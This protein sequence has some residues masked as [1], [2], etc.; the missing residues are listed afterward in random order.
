MK[1]GAVRITRHAIERWRQRVDP[2]ASEEAAEQAIRQALSRAEELCDAE[3]GAKAYLAGTLVL[4]VADNGSL[5]TVCRPEYGFGPAIDE[6]I[7]QKLIEQLHDVRRRKAE[8]RD[9]AKPQLQS[10][11]ARVRAAEDQIRTLQATLERL[12]HERAVIE[13]QGEELAREEQ[14]VAHRL[15]RS[16]DY[17]VDLLAAKFQKAG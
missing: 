16:I 1:G 7:A 15:Y 2:N 6:A 3:D 10:I 17:R 4:I 14:V 11:E 12:R 5:A 13:A 9:Q 8:W